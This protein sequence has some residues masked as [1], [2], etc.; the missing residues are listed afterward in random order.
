MSIECEE[1]GSERVILTI[2]EIRMGRGQ[3][4]YSA[5]KCKNCGMVYP[6]QELAKGMGMGVSKDRIVAMLK[7]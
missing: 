2:H 7:Q 3:V 1:C 4:V 5:M 6:L